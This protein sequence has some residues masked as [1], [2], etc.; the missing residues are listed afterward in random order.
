MRPNEIDYSD[1]RKPYFDLSNGEVLVGREDRERYLDEGADPSDVVALGALLRESPEMIAALNLETIDTSGWSRDRFVQFGRWINRVVDPPSQ[2]GQKRLTRNPVLQNA[3]KL[4]LGPSAFA[5]RKTFDSYGKFYVAIRAKDTHNVGVFKDWELDDF[6]QHVK[7]VGGSKR[8]TKEDL[9]RLSDMNPANPDPE[10]MH[11]RFHDIGGFRAILELAGYPVIDLWDRDDYIDWGVRFM[12]ANN[13][14][15]PTSRMANYLSAKK[16]G[17]A[18]RTISDN[19]TKLSIF[20][21]EVCDEWRRV[22][23]EK[24]KDMED[25]LDAIRAGL[26]SGSL[27]MDLFLDQTQADRTY[28]PLSIEECLE[29]LPAD[30]TIGRYGRYIV[31]SALIPGMSEETKIE[32]ASG[33]HERGFVN[34]I[35]KNHSDISSDQI[36]YEALMLDVFDYIWP[37]DKHMQ[38]LKLDDGYVEYYA[39]LEK[40][41]NVRTPRPIVTLV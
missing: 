22:E 21:N 39:A 23:E 25:K 16:L 15:V 41:K 2:P 31:I 5:V 3:Y 40:V 13:G 38:E 10:Y 12:Q 9:K 7:R 30:E 17:P 20:Q 6:V 18:A 29:Q 27:P 11:Q 8:P 26:A 37:M 24:R 35:R 28:G 34:A 4:G 19:F 32:I 36:E 33:Q 14:V 1:T